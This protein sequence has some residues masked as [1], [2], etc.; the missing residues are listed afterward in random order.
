M[1]LDFIEYFVEDPVG[2]RR[3][4]GDGSRRTANGQPASKAAC[5]YVRRAAGSRVAPSWRCRG[6]NALDA[7]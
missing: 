2:H 7:V 3:S 5:G 1:P 6:G 4:Q